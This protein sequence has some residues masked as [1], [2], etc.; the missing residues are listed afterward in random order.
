MNV[1]IFA[2]IT[3]REFEKMGN[4]AWIY[5]RVFNVTGSLYRNKSNFHGVHIFADIQETRIAQKYLQGEIFYVHSMFSRL[6][7]EGYG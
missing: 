1:A 3:F 6:G 2:C 7:L 5:V 4:F